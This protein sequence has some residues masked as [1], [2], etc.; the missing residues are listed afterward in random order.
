MGVVLGGRADQ[1]GAADVDVF[2]RFGPGRVGAGDGGLKRIEV[3]D[4][5][6]DRQEALPLEGGE[7]VGLVAPGQDSAVDLGVQRLDATAENFGL[8]GVVGD[9]GDIEPGGHEGRPAAAAG[10]ELGA[11]WR[12]GLAPARPDRACRKR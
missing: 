6:V 7:V 3:D 12:P 11:A 9:F 2:D 1:G 4:D 10:Q 5:Q 8:A